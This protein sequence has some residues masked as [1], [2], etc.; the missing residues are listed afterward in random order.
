MARDLRNIGANR[1]NYPD[2]CWFYDRN[3]LNGNELK[4]DAQPLGRFYKRDKISFEWRR[5]DLGGGILSNDYHFI[6]TIETCDHV[7][8]LRVG[9]YVKDQTGMLFQIMS[10]VI[11]DDAN[12]SKVVGTRPSVIT[13]MTL[14]GVEKK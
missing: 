5:I 7:E 4:P 2:R 9:M 13:T 3:C 10:P 6:G 8:K 12:R 14:M 11:S 1:N